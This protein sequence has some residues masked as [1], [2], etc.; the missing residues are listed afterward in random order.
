M[1]E[2]IFTLIL[3]FSVT[4]TLF[5]DSASEKE[6]TGNDAK[7]KKKKLSSSMKNQF[8]AKDENPK[9]IEAMIIHF[10]GVEG[11]KEAVHK[12]AE[13]FEKLV[14]E[15]PE[16]PKYR[17]Y[18]GSSYNLEGRD[19]FFFWTKKKFLDKGTKLL[20]QAVKEA[21]ESTELRMLRGMNNVHLPKFFKRSQL[22]IED[23][24]SILNNKEFNYWEPEFRQEVYYY[25]GLA[26]Q[27]NENEESAKKNWE[28]CIKMNPESKFGKLAKKKMSAE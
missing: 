6:K 21:P 18:L 10:Q 28:I 14:K 16:N 7:T 20:N 5:C 19:A 23:F 22:C 1:K 15:N 26:Y 8:I 13:L 4:G 2:M 3:I 11:D 9:F 12:S 17:A 27:K 24:T 25:L